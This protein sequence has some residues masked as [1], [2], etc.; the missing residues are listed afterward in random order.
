MSILPINLGTQLWGG[1]CCP[2]S[3]SPHSTQQ[4][5]LPVFGLHRELGIISMQQRSKH[6]FFEPG[7]DGMDLRFELPNITFSSTNNYI[8]CMTMNTEVDKV[9]WRLHAML[10]RAAPIDRINH[11]SD[12]FHLQSIFNTLR[13]NAILILPKIIISITTCFNTYGVMNWII[14][15]GCV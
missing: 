13:P 3:S 2:I 15:N 8:Q 6:I 7:L 14:F 5:L 10:H 1:L 4:V 9:M 11:S 12:C